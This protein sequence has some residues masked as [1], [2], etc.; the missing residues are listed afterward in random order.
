MLHVNNESKKAL[1]WGMGKPEEIESGNISLVPRPRFGLW[2]I[3]YSL[4]SEEI[5]DLKPGYV[6]HAYGE[7]TKYERNIPVITVSEIEV[8]AKHRQ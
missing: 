3:N 6:I 2:I 4:V 7:I 8:L 5:E 1:I